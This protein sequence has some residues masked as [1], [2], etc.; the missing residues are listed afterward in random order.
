MRDL[1]SVYLLFEEF[2]VLRLADYE[3]LTQAEAAKKMNISQHLPVFMTRPARM[4]SKHL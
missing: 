2:E 3:N 1:E 4:L